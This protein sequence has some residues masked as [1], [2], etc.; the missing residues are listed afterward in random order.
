MKPKEKCLA[1]L[2]VIA[3]M[4]GQHIFENYECK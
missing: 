3:D 2:D 1:K 4:P